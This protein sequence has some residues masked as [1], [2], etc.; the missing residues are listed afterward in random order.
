MGDRLA[1]METM[2]A[3]L[4]LS[5]PQP[6]ADSTFEPVHL[7]TDQEK[8]EWGEMLPVVE[9]KAKELMAPIE[10]ELKAK[11]KQLDDQLK[12]VGQAQ[13][14]STRTRMLQTL[15][16]DPSIGLGAGENCWRALND[17]DE[18]VK[19]WLQRVE[20]HSG[21]RRH[22]LLK[23]AYDLNDAPRV[24]AFFEDF[25]KEAGRLAPQP[26]P[27]PNGAAAHVAPAPGLERYAAPGS[28]KAAPVAPTAPA[29]PEIFTTGDISRFYADKQAG[30][31]RGR[32]AEAD[33]YERQIF[34]AQNAGR[35]RPGPP[36]P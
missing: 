6:P 11:I 34:A 12:G 31:W 18:F 30:R 28:P 26:S 16:A 32:E 21:R 3:Q 19:D 13:A 7:L 23:E 15:D 27:K 1:Q 20:R 4:S 10:A 8:A 36:Q 5:A 25:L 33:A 17:D 22:D 24:A 14:A 29:E 2:L 9:K 35:I